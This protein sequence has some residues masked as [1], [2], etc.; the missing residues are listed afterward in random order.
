VLKVAG[1][2]GLTAAQQIGIYD[3]LLSGCVIGRVD[4]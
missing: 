3:Q 2:D 1:G 4:A